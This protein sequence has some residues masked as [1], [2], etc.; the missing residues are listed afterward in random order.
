MYSRV[1]LVEIDT[2]RIGVEEALSLFREE[3][4]S[5]LADQE[6]YEGVLA[7]ANPDGR[8]MI[9]TLWRTEEAARSDIQHGGF[10]AEALERFVTFFRQPPGRAS[11]EV[12]IADVPVLADG[13]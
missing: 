10:Y 5:R 8:G 11:Y 12:M 9:V 2:V 3:L 4:L 13:G 7:M 1:T 6:G